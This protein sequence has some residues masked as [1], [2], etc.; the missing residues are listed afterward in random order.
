MKKLILLSLFS[1][2]SINL[3]AQRYVR[4]N[5]TSSTNL[6]IGLQYQVATGTCILDD[7]NE[8]FIPSSSTHTFFIP[9]GVEAW[10]VLFNHA[11]DFHETYPPCD[12]CS[13]DVPGEFNFTW[14]ILEDCDRLYL[15]ID[16]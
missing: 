9:A 3:S 6:T 16:N 15:T 1:I 7:E 4:V 8:Q 10:R 12:P 2:L 5:N 11:G 13:A 14:V